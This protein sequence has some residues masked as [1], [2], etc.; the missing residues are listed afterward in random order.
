MSEL[1][2]YAG[3]EYRLSKRNADGQSLRETLETVKRMTGRMPVE[4]LNPVEFPIELYDEWGWFLDLHRTRQTGLSDSP[5]AESEIGWYFFNRG[6]R[7]Q[8]W[9]LRLIRRLETV[10]QSG[11]KA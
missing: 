6:T 4:G 7:P 10:A 9:L 1:V 11:G 2:A 3:H 5:I 8:G